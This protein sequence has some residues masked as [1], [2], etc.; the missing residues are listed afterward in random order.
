MKTLKLILAGILITVFASTADAQYVLDGVYQKEHTVKR[1]VIPYAH[2]REGD[3][4]WLKRVWRRMDMREKIN[5]PLYYPV[6]PI[7]DRQNLFDVIREALLESGTITAYSVG[8]IGT[9]DEFT[10]P[11]TV[12]EVKNLLSRMDTQYVENIETEEFEEVA[13]AIEVE[14]SEILWYEIKEEWFFDRQRSV[15][16]VRIVGIC[17]MKNKV[18]DFGESQG[19]QPLFWLYYPEARFVFNEQE[20]YNRQ[21]DSERRTLEDIIWSRQFGS[22]IIK[23]SNVYDRFINE[24]KSGL[25]ALLEAEKIKEMLFLQEHDVWHF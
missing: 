1:R 18:N 11:M 13:Q 19:P 8:P 9:D 14:S 4:M 21:N 23:Q 2:L 20:V 24:Y 12:E 6:S 7:N 15:M 5:Y 17:P 10:T 25:N 16:D 3:V 22:Y